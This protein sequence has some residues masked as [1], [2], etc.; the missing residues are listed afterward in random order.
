VIAAP[1]NSD[2]TAHV[3]LPRQLVDREHFI[4]DECRGQRVLH[5]GF[6]DHPYLAERLANGTWLHRRLFGVARELVGVDTACDEVEQLR[7]RPDVGQVLCG[8]AESLEQ[9]ELPPFER[10]VAGE[11]ME[12]L[13]NVGLFLGSVKS[14]L[15]PDGRLIISVPNAFCLRR[16]LRVAFGVESVHPDHVAYY[17]H[18]TLKHL[19]TRYGY[20]IEHVAGYRLPVGTPR[21]AY[22]LDR[23]ASLLSPNLCEGLVYSVRVGRG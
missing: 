10:I 11:L 13:N 6:V 23:A 1:P 16:T 5:L 21:A 7:G 12:H 2:G 20:V 8:D 14:L 4:L 3:R 22:L 15:A 9:L 19:L 17:S 18:A